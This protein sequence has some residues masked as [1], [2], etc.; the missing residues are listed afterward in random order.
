M[1]NLLAETEP[2]QEVCF[3]SSFCNFALARGTVLTCPGE[4]KP[5]L[6]LGKLCARKESRAQSRAGPGVPGA[7]ENHYL[8]N[9]FCKRGTTWE[10]KETHWAFHVKVAK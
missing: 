1:L 6:F 9:I 2:W 5:L 10:K 8:A 7:T 4:W 3:S